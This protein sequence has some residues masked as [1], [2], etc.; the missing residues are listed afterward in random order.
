MNEKTKAKKMLKYFIGMDIH[1][2]STTICV[3]N[4][5]GEVYDARTLPTTERALREYLQTMPASK[6]LV[7]EETSL[8]QWLYTVLH[9]EVDDMVVCDP[10]RNSLLKDGAKTDAIDA[11][12]LADLYR[13]G[14]INPV[15]HSTDSRME[16][17]KLCSV[18]RNV[19]HGLVQVQNQQQ[20]FLRRNGHQEEQL[21]ALEKRIVHM[22]NE[23]WELYLQQRDLLKKDL[24]DLGKKY[25]E[26]RILKSHPG[27]GP[28]GAVKIM[29]CVIDP[30]RFPTKHKFWSYCGLVRHPRESAGKNAGSKKA[31]GN[32]QLK[33]VFKTAV[34]TVLQGEKLTPMK[35]YY[36]G[37]IQKGLTERNARQALAR[38]IAANVLACWKKKEYFKADYEAQKE[39]KAKNMR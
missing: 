27:I 10:Y 1:A 5:Q 36:N 31:R 8:S 19:T 39:R 22:H 29:A 3:L 14:L 26:I 25:Q 33:C 28:I 13:V 11:H 18:Y 6:G 23:R 20:A 9:E 15:F 21:T 38:K 30:K 35:V 4:A 37:L 7:I 2:Q 34:V 12:K 16:V 17:R 32:R 24:E